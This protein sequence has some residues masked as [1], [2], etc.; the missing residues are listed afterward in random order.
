MIAEECMPS[1]L[2]PGLGNVRH[3]FHSHPVGEN[4]VSGHTNWQGKL[5]N[6]VS[7]G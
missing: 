7:V 6:G 1:V 5:G 3:H 4:F 2:R